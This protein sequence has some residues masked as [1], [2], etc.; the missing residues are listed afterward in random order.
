MNQMISM[1]EVLNIPGMSERLMEA[2]SADELMEI[3]SEN[4]VRLEDGATY[5]EAFEALRKGIEDSANE[6]DELGEDDLQNV[7]G[8]FGVTG[9]LIL[10]GGVLVAGPT[11]VYGIGRLLGRKLARI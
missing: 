3:F 7:A 8:G 6:D 10:I 1:E 4:S 2:K 5:E 9:T 11:V